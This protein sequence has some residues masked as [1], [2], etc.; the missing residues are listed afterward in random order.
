MRPMMSALAL[1]LLGL[2]AAHESVES[3]A[4]YQFQVNEPPRCFIAEDGSTVV[5]YK[6]TVRILAAA[7]AARAC[8]RQ[9]Q[10]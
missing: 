2:V 7:I 1:A 5:Q 4:A 9:R 10:S 3:V 8:A 6:G